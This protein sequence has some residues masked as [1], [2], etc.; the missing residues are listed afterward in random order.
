LAGAL[1]SG[2]C[3]PDQFLE[4]CCLSLKHLFEKIFPEKL[5]H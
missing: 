3:Y 1:L 4:H 5:G 2:Y